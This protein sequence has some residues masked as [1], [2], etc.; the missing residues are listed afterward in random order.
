MKDLFRRLTWGFLPAGWRRIVLIIFLTVGTY[1]INEEYPEFKKITHT[2]LFPDGR[3]N[4]D[5]QY[6]TYEFVRDIGVEDI[7]ISIIA[8]MLVSLI[9]SWVADGFKKT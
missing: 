7:F 6:Y 4:I 5:K 1:Y 3:P 9:A 2:P 8:A